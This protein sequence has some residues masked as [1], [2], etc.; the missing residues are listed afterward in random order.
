MMA[1]L[2]QASASTASKQAM[3]TEDQKAAFSLLTADS[4]L[5][6]T[7]SLSALHQLA[8]YQQHALDVTTALISSYSAGHPSATCR[9]C[10]SDSV[11]CIFFPC[12]HAV[13][14][15]DCADDCEVCPWPGCGRRV[16]EA[17]RMLDKLP[18]ALLRMPD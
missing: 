13:S 3:L 7:L 16:E 9:L 5:M 2:D 14:C 4:E 6:P 18:Q 15:E 10:D 8:L 11:S 1:L 17:Q 12:Q